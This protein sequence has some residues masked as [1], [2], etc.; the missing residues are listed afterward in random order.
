MDTGARKPITTIIPQ[1]AIAASATHRVTTVNGGN[2]FTVTPMKKT[3]PLHST[4]NR[5]SEDR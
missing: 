1:S 5:R 3:G 4:D 2:S